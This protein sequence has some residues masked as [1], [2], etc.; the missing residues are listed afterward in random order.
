M[1]RF[2]PLPACDGDLP[3]RLVSGAEAVLR[4]AAAR[5]VEVCFANP[6]TTEMPLV[7]ALEAVPAIR[8]V[9]GLHENV[10]TGAAD[11]FARMTGRPA[12][13]LLHLGVGLGNGVSN[14]HNARRARSPGLVVVGDHPRC[15]RTAGTPLAMDL[16][17]LASAVCRCVHAAEDPATLVQE[18]DAA[19]A[20][21]SSPPAGPA[22]LLLPHDVQAQAIGWDGASARPLAPP[23]A[24]PGQVGVEAAARALLQGG[25]RAALLLG[26]A[27]LHGQGLVLARRIADATGCR[28]LAEV[29]P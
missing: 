20:A 17:R 28:L 1:T 11:G 3:R 14:L 23:A 26:G 6:G 5:G 18:V 2:R 19:L 9:L 29:W 7:E 12:M 15:H 8:P 24:P 21:A 13:S 27:A 4:V 25:S 10:C 16:P 22:V